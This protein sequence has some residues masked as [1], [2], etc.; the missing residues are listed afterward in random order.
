VRRDDRWGLFAPD[1]GHH[2]T[3]AKTLVTMNS[4][5]KGFAPLGSGVERPYSL[6]APAARGR[7][8]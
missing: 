1:H 8:P 4:M 7:A 3:V 5:P 2:V 6:A